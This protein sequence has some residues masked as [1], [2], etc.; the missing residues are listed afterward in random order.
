MSDPKDHK[1]ADQGKA[2]AKAEFSDATLDAAQKAGLA[3]GDFLNARKRDT[4]RP[5]VTARDQKIATSA[6]EAE[7]AVE[8]AAANIKRFLELQNRELASLIMRAATLG[9]K[10]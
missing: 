1:P 7:I 8:I 4:A 5:A 6:Y 10:K 3:L 9:D 2:D